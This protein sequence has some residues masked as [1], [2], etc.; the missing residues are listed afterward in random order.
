MS[1]ALDTPIIRLLN[2]LDKAASFHHSISSR[3]VVNVCRLN[4][5]VPVLQD[6]LVGRVP[7]TRRVQPRDR[8]IRIHISPRNQPIL[9]LRLV[10]RVRHLI[11]DGGRIAVVARVPVVRTRQLAAMILE[12]LER[13]RARCRT[14][15]PSF[16]I[17]HHLLNN[18]RT[19]CWEKS[20]LRQ[21]QPELPL[22][23][24]VHG[25]E[26]RQLSIIGKTT[27]SF[28]PLRQ[29]ANLAWRHSRFRHPR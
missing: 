12:R 7:L 13:I 17:F 1:A 24:Q 28:R 11:R 16:E 10:E 23:F 2:R 22:L 20:R 14:T 6:V 5:L 26:P 19:R 18:F 27:I 29:T 4:Q 25:R 9:S 15:M 8:V 3:E 21:L